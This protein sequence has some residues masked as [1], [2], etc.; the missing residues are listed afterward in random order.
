MDDLISRNEAIKRIK[1]MA[2]MFTDEGFMVDYV[3]VLSIIENLPS[4]QP[5]QKGWICPVCGRG[6][7]PYTT[8]CPCKNGEGWEI[9]C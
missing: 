1:P 7:S 6:L 8:V 2:G 4:A 3:A 9:T 5:E